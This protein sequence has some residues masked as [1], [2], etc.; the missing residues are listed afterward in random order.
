[1][2]WTSSPAFFCAAT[3]TGRDI[4]EW[5]RL[6][7]HLPPHPLE[8]HTLAHP[9][10]NFYRHHFPDPSSLTDPVKRKA[11]FHLFEVFVDDYIGLLQSTDV[12]ALR[13]H[14]RAL[15]HGIHQVFPPPTATG[16][17]SEDPISHKKLVVDGEG[18]WDTT[19]EILGWIFDGLHRTMQL[20]AK[21]V[22]AIR[23]TIKNAL[24]SKHI[25]LKAF[26]SLI[27]K[28]QHACLGIPG[29]TA[30]LGPLYR[31]STRPKTPGRQPSRSIRA[32]LSSQLFL[33]SGLSSRF[34]GTTLSTA[35][36]SSQV[37]PLT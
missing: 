14:S 3:E 5:L 36:S 2:G 11:F 1:M 19:K 27:G 34:L 15:L 10:P 37:N 28:C 35:S 17:T 31:P 29:G 8:A 18:I 20:P 23:E 6:L 7:P 22:H 12:H 33:T 4:A 26:E 25:E 13:H 9:D 32:P 21:K 24:R 16:A 30:L